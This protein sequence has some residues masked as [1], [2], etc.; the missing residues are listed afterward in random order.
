MFVNGLRTS[1]VVD[2]YVP[3]NP[4]TELPAFFHSETQE[5]WALLL[6]KAWAKLHGSYQ[7]TVEGLPSFASMHL[8]GSPA[9]H[10]A[11]D[12]AKFY[13]GGSGWNDNLEKQEEFWKKIVGAHSRSYSL[14]ASAK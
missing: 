14:M 9:D 13:E 3:V 10:L 4:E 12:Q 2:D 1:V 11:S 7:K 5:L 8:T 6:E